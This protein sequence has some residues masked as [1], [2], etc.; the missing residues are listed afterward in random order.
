M[1]GVEN[2]Q[3]DMKLH[4]NDFCGDSVGCSTDPTDTPIREK[5]SDSNTSS[6]P[7]SGSGA[8]NN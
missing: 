7:S 8:G 6:T 3:G 4:S 5:R 1:S 2:G